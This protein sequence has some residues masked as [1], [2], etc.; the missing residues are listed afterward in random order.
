VSRAGL[1]L[2]LRLLPGSEWERFEHFCSQFLVSDYPEL[3]TTANPAGDGGRDAFLYLV[4]AQSNVA[5]QYSLQLDWREKV[6][7]TAKR[8]KVTFPNVSVLVFMSNQLIGAAGDDLR[9]E[10]SQSGIYLDIRDRSWFLERFDTN[11]TRSRA[12]QELIDAS[13][14]PAL[15]AESITATSSALTRSESKTLLLFLELQRSDEVAEKGLTRSCFEALVRA[16]LRDTSSHNR[17]SKEEIYNRVSSFLPEHDP[18]VLRPHVDAVLN[19]LAKSVIKHRRSS[20]DYHIAYEESVRLAE[21]AAF[22]ESLRLDFEADVRDVVSCDPRIESSERDSVTVYIAKLVETYL[23]LRGEQ[24]AAAVTTGA[25]LLDSEA[26]LDSV[27]TRLDPP[28]LANGA[29]G[30]VVCADA[31]RNLLRTPSERTLAYLK[32][33]SDCYTLFS[34]LAETPNVQ[35]VVKRIFDRGDIWLDTSIL[36]PAFAEFAQTSDD[37]VSR[38]FG[39]L[40]RTIRDS[41]TRLHVTTG[42]IEEVERHINLCRTYSRADRWVGEVPYVVGR[43][44]ISGGTRA[45]FV[46]FSESFCEDNTRAGDDIA[47]FIKE[48]FGIAVTEAQSDPRIPESV[49]LEISSFWQEI[50]SSRRLDNMTSML[51]ARHDAENYIN[52]LSRRLGEDHTSWLGYKSWWLTLDSYARRLFD[53]NAS[54]ESRKVILHQPILSMDFLAQHL[55]FGSLRGRARAMEVNPLQIYGQAIKETLP[56]EVIERADELRGQFEGVTERLKIRRIRNEL[57]R[58]RATYGVVHRSGIEGLPAAVMSQEP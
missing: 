24:F 15:D 25:S 9:R 41:G 51:L 46:G 54:D 28:I 1:E 7:R 30:S 6:R 21:R 31:F 49:K 56:R 29:N 50:H 8:L 11:A 19:R 52:V 12:A 37:S 27:I 14:T 38:P 33:L 23:H 44:L 4:G 3:R 5:F 48:E 2:C 18:I 47:I 45:M 58:Q 35:K 32:L 34:F 55:T 22:V 36:L 53:N 43:Y 42:V 26:M 13:I 40:L 17:I 20:E 16:A 39:N 10:L 57:D